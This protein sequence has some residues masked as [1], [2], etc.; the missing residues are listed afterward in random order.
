MKKN[1]FKSIAIVGM[2]LCSS[3]QI[4]Q[5]QSKIIAFPTAEGFG[6]YASGGRGGQVV[7]V[8]NLLDYGSTETP[9]PGSFRWALKQYPGEPLTVIFR[10]SGVVQLKA[11]PNFS[12][13]RN[14]NDI[15]S[16]RANLTIA[17][18]TAP[19]EGITFRGAKLNFG[20]SV[21]LII[22]NI[23]S[24]IGLADDGTSIFGGSIGIENGSNWIVDHCSF[25][26]SIEEN[27]T[28]YDNNYTTVQNTIV[29]EGLYEG[30]HLKGNRSYGSQWGGQSATYYHNLLA[31]NKTRS[32]RFNGARSDNDIKVFIEFS[33]NVDY[34]WGN[35]NACYGSD[36][37]T[38]LLRYNNT[39]F[40]NNYYKPGPA[41]NSS[42]NFTQV[43][44]GTNTSI[45]AKFYFAGNIMEGSQAITDNPW[46]GVNNS[47]SFTPAQLKSDTL[48]LDK[49]FDY[50]EYKV[51]NLKTAQ[52]AYNDVV[53]TVGPIV[54][55]TVDRRIINEVK[56]KNNTVIGAAGM[57]GIID[58]PFQVEGYPAYYPATAPL[59]A[60]NDG[61]ADA[62]ELA[63]GL[64]PEFSSD[65]NWRT[66]EGYT[67]LEVYLAS[68]MGETITHNFVTGLN[69]A[70]Q[71][72]TSVWPTMVQEQLNIESN[73]Q[74]IHHL[75]IYNIDGCKTMEIPNPSNTIQ[76][77]TLKKGWYL[78]EIALL[79][80]SSELFR[81]LR[82]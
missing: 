48:I 54:R 29:H 46:L 10:V 70:K 69:A 28:I 18:Q 67:A 56:T 75:T 49:R 19:G 34:N 65:R 13:G 39:N 59:D 4:A 37:A 3:F 1:P 76:L 50:Y 71:K 64:N 41:T 23:R 63:N 36:I 40:L 78:V 74:T 51:K 80:G 44:A 79:N 5:A 14:A 77:N 22:R 73:Q 31:N 43:S 38:G 35:Y 42:L 8:D 60:D 17:G 66:A 11:E 12:T 72:Y 26:W 57:K 15:R 61:M 52:Q 9:I 81:I 82:Q 55:D 2:L 32:P 25:G 20:G 45:P 16:S 30:G 58:S 27:M 53:A 24:R 68:L 21:N 7:F 6:K 62:W 47:T 33:N